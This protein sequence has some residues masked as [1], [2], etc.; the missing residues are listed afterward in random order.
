MFKLLK[1]SN[2]SSRFSDKTYF[3]L[4]LAIFERLSVCSQ[5]RLIR[6]LSRRLR[7][8][9]SQKGEFRIDSGAKYR[10][11]LSKVEKREWKVCL[12]LD[13]FNCRSVWQGRCDLGAKTTKTG[14]SL[15]CRFNIVCFKLKV[16]LKK[17]FKKP[18]IESQK[19]K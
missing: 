14:V 2:N 11:Y 5:T 12:H 16:G 9:S 15:W 10:G 4:L 13:N 6:R 3:D 7:Y 17:L 8:V 1:S 19:K 18:I